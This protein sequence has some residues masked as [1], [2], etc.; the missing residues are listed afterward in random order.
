MS[1][2]LPES[3]SLEHL[4]NEAKALKKIS[5]QRLA[6]AQLQVAR[7]YGF[8]SWAKLKN[9]VEGFSNF[10]QGFFQAIRSGDRSKVQHLL[11]DSP[12]LIRSHDPDSFGQVPISAAASR[13]DIAMIELL[14]SNGADVD[15]RSDWWAGSFGALDF[16]NESTAKYLIEHGATLTAHAA[17]R[18]GMA[19]ELRAMVADDSSVVHERGGD[20]QFPLHFAS[21]AEIVEIL[22]DAG[23]DPDARDIDHEGT[24]AQWRIKNDPVLGRLVKLGASTD[25]F[26]AI[27]LDDP[28]LIEKHLQEEPDRAACLVRKATEPGNPMIPV[29]APGGHIYTYELGFASPLQVA[30]NLGK[31]RAYAF[32]FEQ[33]PPRYQL[34]AAAWKG[35]ADQAQRLRRYVAELS[36]QEASQIADAAR[37]K[38]HDLLKLMIELGFP[39]DAQD[40]EG[41][42]ALHWTGFHGDLDGMKLV[43]DQAPNLEILNGYGGNALSTTCYGSMHGWYAKSGQYP[44]CV[45]L[46]VQSGAVPKEG[47]RGSQAVNEVLDRMRD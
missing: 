13:D 38:R 19:N 36:R 40:H 45:R 47:L 1:K 22:I 29:T 26:I 2:S 42:T 37:N 17:A 4:K 16:C 14:I 28:W 12:G 34:L 15:A 6:E 46:L 20:G 9:H 32:L 35:D 8:A 33:S 24:A 10:R 25:I 39:M 11:T 21:T 41:M 23:A 27:A 43:L 5:G 18:L 7:E 44:D 31:D 30:A 3:P